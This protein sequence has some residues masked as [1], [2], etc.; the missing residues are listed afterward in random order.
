MSEDGLA[1]ASLCEAFQRT[2]A[3]RP[4]EVALRTPGG[5]SVL[6]WGDYA[7][8]VRR[9]AAG[10]AALGVGRG[11][12]V[13]LMMVNRPEFNLCDSAALHLGA[14]P[15]SVYNTSTPEQISYLFSNAGNRVVLCERQFAPSVQG[16]RPGTAVEHVVCVDGAAEGAIALADLEQRGEPDF[17]FEAAWRAVRPDDLLTLIYTS[18][19][20]GPPKGV[21]MTHANMLA[22]LRATQAVLPVYP[23]DRQASYLPSAHIADR[24]GTHYQ[25]MAFG[26]EVT[27]VADTR[28]VAAAL[29]EVRPTVW[30]AVPRVW[31]KIH[32]ALAARIDSEPDQKR[33]GA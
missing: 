13:A 32:A 9:I 1:L 5:G 29:P 16:A 27:C 12:T 30:G 2:A 19:T 7:E 25:G 26:L 23:G 4:S 20:T 14:V 21:E 6:T 8:R 24:W 18:G 11:D 31:E 3:T 10:L 28:A 17:D 33:A 15:F 22:E